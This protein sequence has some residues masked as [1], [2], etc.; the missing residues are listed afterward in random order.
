M[1]FLYWFTETL[2]PYEHASNQQIHLN[3]FIQLFS[4]INISTRILSWY[5]FI[6]SKEEGYDICVWQIIWLLKVDEKNSIIMWLLGFEL[7]A[8][9]FKGDS[10]IFVFHIQL[11]WL[12]KV[13]ERSQVI[14]LLFVFG[15][16]E[17]LGGDFKTFFLSWTS[18]QP[19]ASLVGVYVIEIHM[20][21]ELGMWF[22]NETCLTRLLY[23]STN[24]ML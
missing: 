20:E 3:F 13:N 16:L 11:I 10:R 17:W 23:L 9:D 24:N 7:S 6:T 18:W 22:Y 15:Q 5:K 1:L 12:L 2:T 21:C 19:C 4:V 8:G 14:V